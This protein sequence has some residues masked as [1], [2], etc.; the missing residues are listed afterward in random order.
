MKINNVRTTATKNYV[1]DVVAI[2]Y[3]HGANNYFEMQI[4]QFFQKVQITKL[5]T[6]KTTVM[7]VTKFKI[8]ISNLCSNFDIRESK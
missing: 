2:W 5:W 4:E 1:G 3:S 6:H 7:R 8:Q